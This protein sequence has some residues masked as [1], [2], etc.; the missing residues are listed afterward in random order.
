VGAAARSAWLAGWNSSRAAQ[1]GQL[2]RADAIVRALQAA[3]ADGAAWNY[4]EAVRAKLGEGASWPD[5]RFPAPMRVV[6]QV[7]WFDPVPGRSLGGP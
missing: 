7:G 2:E 1:R 4:V 6:V 3:G 5:A